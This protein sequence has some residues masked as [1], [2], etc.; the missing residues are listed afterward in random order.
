MAIWGAG[1][2]GGSGPASYDYVQTDQPQNPQ[3]GETWYD[4]D[5]DSAYVY[6]GAAWVEMTVTDHAQLSNVTASQHHTRP[7]YTNYE[8]GNRAGGNSDFKQS[9]PVHGICE[10]LDRVKI[11]LTSAGTD[12]K[13]TIWY[14][15][16]S[17][18]EVGTY[19]ENTWASCNSS[20]MVVAISK[21]GD[22]SYLSGID[23]VEMPRHNHSI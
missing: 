20:K 23:P 22:Y 10:Y 21:A 8:G 18:E 7:N 16:G 14:G 4:V 6:D 1:G 11:D 2:S 5:G 17:S 19:A 12:G 9:L 13:P 15:D 3:E